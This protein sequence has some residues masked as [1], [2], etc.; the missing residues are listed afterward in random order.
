MIDL[1]LLGG[2]TE[3]SHELARLFQSAGYQVEEVPDLASYLNRPLGNLLPPDAG[4]SKGMAVTLPCSND[5]RDIRIFNARASD[6]NAG[7]F[8]CQPNLLTFISNLARQLMPG[9]R[10]SMGSRCLEA[11]NRRI[12]ELTSLEFKFIKNFALVEVNEAISRKQIVQ[13][14]GEDYLSY[15]QNRIDTM[16][17]RLRKKVELSV[18]VKLPLNTERVRGFSFGHILIIDP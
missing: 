10:L 2:D 4:I 11:P 14:F 3:R 18:G 8:Q 9:W 5:S 16:L 7:A 1:L 13:A 12:V 17:R 15:D 6:V